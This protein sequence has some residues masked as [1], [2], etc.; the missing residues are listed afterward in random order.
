MR[1]RV[2]CLALNY[3]T[4]LRVDHQAP[5]GRVGERDG[6]R[7]RKAICDE[8]HTTQTVGRGPEACSRGPKKKAKTVASNPQTEQN[9]RQ[10]AAGQATLGEG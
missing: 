1:G 4:R 10:E 6:R 2:K 9:G 8:E 7:N 5:R 3:K